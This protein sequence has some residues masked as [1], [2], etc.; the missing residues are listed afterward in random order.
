[1]DGKR[2]A[3]ANKKNETFTLK[4]SKKKRPRIAAPRGT[5]G[6]KRQTTNLRA[7][8]KEEKTN[9]YRSIERQA[10]IGRRALQN[11]TRHREPSCGE[12]WP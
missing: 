2:A 8:S 1:V 10:S 6:W 7:E 3:D 12:T 11:T 9:N 5:L 4:K